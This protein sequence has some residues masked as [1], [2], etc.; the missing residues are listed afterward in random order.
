MQW[1]EATCRRAVTLVAQVLLCLSGTASAQL[2][3]P[4]G[5]C[6]APP[7]QPIERPPIHRLSLTTPVSLTTRVAKVAHV[8][9]EW[10][11]GRWSV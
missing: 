5:R 6:L 1:S 2:V 11:A 9:G 7:W 8:W 3:C 10:S 4:D